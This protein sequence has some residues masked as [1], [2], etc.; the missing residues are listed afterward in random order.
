M[1]LKHII[2][3]LFVLGFMQL[4]AQAPRVFTED[5][6]K[7]VDE[8]YDL[9]AEADKRDAKDWREKFEPV[10]SGSYYTPEERKWIYALANTMSKKRLLVPPFKSFVNTVYGFANKNQPHESLKGWQN[11]IDKLLANKRISSAQFVDFL[12]MTD[13]LLSANTMYASP[14][15]TWLSSNGNFSFQYDSIPKVIFSSC[16]LI[17]RAKGDSAVIYSTSGIYYPLKFK[18][19]GKNGKVTW[20]RAG[21]KKDDV[22]ADLKVYTLNVKNPKYTADSVTMHYK[23]YFDVP[24]QGSLEERVIADVDTNRA[25]YPKFK[26][27]KSEFV[28]KNI[29]PD[30]DYEGGIT[31]AGAK[32]I[33]SGVGDQMAKFTFNRDKKKFLVVSSSSMSIRD[34]RF[35]AKVASVT[36]FLN[37]DSIYHPGLNFKYFIKDKLVSLLREKEGTGF[38]PY[39]NTFHKIDMYFEALYWRTDQPLIELRP[40]KGTNQGDANF[41]SANFYEDRRFTEIQGIDPQNPLIIIR[42]FMNQRNGGKRDFKAGDLAGFWKIDITQVRQMLMRLANMGFL[43]YD[44]EAEKG[45]IKDKTLDYINSKA[46]KTDYDVIQFLSSADLRDTT[47]SKGRNATINLLNYDL[48]IYG[49]QKIFLSDSQRVVIFPQNREVLVKKNRDFNF[50]GLIMAGNFELYGKEFEFLY[51][52]FKVELKNVD[53]TKIRVPQGGKDDY[54][55]VKTV[56]LKSQIENITGDLLIDQPYNKSG[57]KPFTQYPIFNSAKNSFVY[58]DR[59]NIE[60]GVYKRDNFYFKLDPFTIDSL[61]NFDPS[62][63]ALDGTFAS[64]GIFEDMR[65]KIRVQPDLSL[66]FMQMTATAGLPIYKNKATFSDTLMLSNN[67]LRGAGKLTYLASTAES[68]N[69]IFYPDSMNAQARKFDMLKAVKDGAEFPDIKAQDVRI[70]WDTKKENS[71]FV[72]NTT[73]PLL[74]YKEESKLKGTIQVGKA[75]VRGKGLMDLASAE[76]E[77]KDFKFKKDDFKSDSL[78]FRLTSLKDGATNKEDKEVAFSTGNVKADVSMNSREGKFKSNSKDSYVDFPINKYVCYMDEMRWNM[79]KDE[80]D[81]NSTI[82]DVDL[83]GAKFVSTDPGQDSLTFIAAQ[84]RFNLKEKTIYCSKVPYVDV[85]DARVFPGDGN[86]RI[87]KSGRMEDLKNAKIDANRDSK[88]YNIYNAT[89]SIFSRKGYSGSG[90]ID[91]LDEAGKKQPIAISSIGVD[92]AGNTKGY[93]EIGEDAKFTISPAFDFKGAVNF[94]AS[95]P[96]MTFTGGARMR[97]ACDKLAKYWL[98]FATVIDPKEVY[99]PVDTM[100]M[101]LEGDKLSAGLI[102]VK[103]STHIYPAVISKK[104][105]TADVDI[106]SAMGFLTYDAASGEYQIGS[107]E[108]LGNNNIPGQYISLNNKTCDVHGEG[109]M[110]LGTDYGRV[111]T[112]VVGAVDNSMATEKTTFDV[113]MTMDFFLPPDCWKQMTNLLVTYGSIPPASQNTEKFK[114]AIPYI[115]KDKKDADRAVSEAGSG[116]AM[117]KMPDEFKKTIVFSDITFEWNSTSRSYISKGDLGIAYIGGEPVNKKI[118]GYVELVKKRGGDVF[119]IYIEPDGSNWYYFY[120][121]AGEM[122]ALSG[123]AAFNDVIKGIDPEKRALDTKNGEKPYRFN[124]GT[125]RKKKDFVNRMQGLE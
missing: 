66:G 120:Y 58:Y 8:L 86:V 34:D 22:Y 23:K 82:K 53:S 107:K 96:N 49:V 88:F 50:S 94:T 92:P 123:S 25:S 44:I 5:P 67:G 3:L 24:I 89:A 51:D 20:E 114:M 59:K 117:K 60:Q 115:V 26:S 99:I 98:K 40:I 69:F 105:R 95:S 72:S 54:G 43:L 111:T 31:I 39:F 80:V 2:A 7:F 52:K 46:G 100:P 83:L 71:F 87:E 90:M 112:A 125:D 11:S 1:K 124:A 109:I 16:N 103:D 18:W 74:M 122:Q 28:I 77:S 85:A 21:A 48:K 9:F 42:N 6:V 68:S 57:L 38:S 78:D 102:L 45:Y 30:V 104:F 93:G 118:K 113:V 10:W 62:A 55:N 84:A 27:Y 73:K 37:E 91:Y 4:K 70:H 106:I 79:D 65:E 32:L 47:R 13:N 97:H 76:L 121:S 116:G 29:A 33:G 17:C 41:E 15:A 110:N 61:D 19:D 108:K 63:L 14:G 119:H 56:R 75:G 64:A 36:F 35:D 81:L 12:E 101:S